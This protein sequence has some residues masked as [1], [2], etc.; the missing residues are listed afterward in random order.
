MIRAP[1]S[2]LH[3]IVEIADFAGHASPFLS[4]IV[5]R[6]AL[7]EIVFVNHAIFD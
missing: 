5:L 6:P 2:F 7:P 1:G 4:V 3:W